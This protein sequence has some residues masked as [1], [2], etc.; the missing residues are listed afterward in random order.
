MS[1]QLESD[2]NMTPAVH[3]G[4]GEPKTKSIVQLCGNNAKQCLH[5]E[6]CEM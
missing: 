4:A 6:K 2:L 3:Q 5:S 1:D